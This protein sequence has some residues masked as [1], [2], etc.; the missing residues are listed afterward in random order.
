HTVT[1]AVGHYRFSRI[2]IQHDTRVRVSD[3][4]VRGRRS[5]TIEVDVELPAYPSSP[6]VIAAARY[7]A[8]RAGANAFAVIDDHGRL[9]GV[10]VHR[11]YHSASIVKS[12]LLVAYLRMLADQSRPLDGASQA[13]LYPM[14]HSSD[15]N[16]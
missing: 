7:L 15:N 3:V 16:A 10:D 1:A 9:A 14:I 5:P 4:Q 2:R 13:L 6:R 12:M 11:R 8:A